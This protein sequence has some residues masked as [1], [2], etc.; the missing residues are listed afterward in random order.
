EEGQSLLYFPEGTR[1]RDGN[2]GNFKR[3]MTKFILKTYFENK[4]SQNIDDILFVP[5]GLAY[6]RVPEDVRFSKN[7]K[8]NAEKINLIKDFFD[9]RK[10][11][12][13][14]YM[15]I[16]KSISLN[17]FFNDNLDLQGHLGKAVKDLSKYLKQ[18]LS[19]T[20]P[21]LQQD[22]YYSAIAHCLESSK[23]DTIYLKNLRKRVNEICVRLYD[24]YSPKLLKAKEGM[25]DFLLRLHERELLFNGQITIK[26][27]NKKIMEY[28]SNKLSSFYE[29]HKLDNEDK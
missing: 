26:I 2:L 16:G 24:S 22:I 27:K 9:F 13:V 15:H 14:N 20:I 29:N 7:K 21:I 10:D 18:E 25:G 8:S 23:T 3:G 28:Y 6:S 1:S 19:K 17:D 12:I 4:N 11:K 5:I